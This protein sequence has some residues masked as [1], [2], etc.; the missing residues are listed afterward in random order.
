MKAPPFDYAKPTSLDEVFRL[1]AEHG[2]QARLLAGGQT[3]LATLNMRLSEPSML[4]DIAGIAEL[5]GIS[6]KDGVL[7]IGAL[8]TH[9]EIEA[10]ALVA[11]HAPLLTAAAPHI[12]H[13]AIRNL[14]TWGGSI[15]YADPAAEWPT[16]LVALEGTVVLRSAR[17]ERRVAAKDFFIDLYTTALAE[18]ELVTACEVPLRVQADVFVFDELSRRHGDYAIVGLALAAQRSAATATAATATATA[19]ANTS[20]PS[21]TRTRLVFLGMGNTPVRAPRCEALLQSQPLTPELI[22]TAMAALKRELR[23]MA[24][25]TNSVDTK[26][27]LA[28]VLARRAL[29]HLMRQP[30]AA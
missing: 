24:D 10:S 12:A 3:L 26:R 11:E 27:H 9:S 22:D 19:T 21:L 29:T 15:A 20:S 13:R 14:G 2:D 18:G 17:G 8:V 5:N 28:S 6:V 30:A 1:M 7:S 25:L 16:C 4:I 23:P